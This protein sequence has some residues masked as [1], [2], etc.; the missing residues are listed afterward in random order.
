[1]EKLKPKLI[2]KYFSPE[3]K[4]VE[5]EYIIDKALKLYFDIQKKELLNLVD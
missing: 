1:M 2:N 4:R 3:I 5:I